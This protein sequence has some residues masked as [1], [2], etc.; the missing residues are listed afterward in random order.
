MGIVFLL[1]ILLILATNYLVSNRNIFFPSVIVSAVFFIS[2][3]LVVLNQSQWDYKVSFQTVCFISCALI[4][5][6]IGVYVGN[7]VG[8]LARYKK[9]TSYLDKNSFGIEISGFNM[10]CLSAISILIT[11]S[12][13]LHQY[14][15]AESLGNTRGLGGVIETIRSQVL[16]NPDVFQLGIVLNVGIVFVRALGFVCLFMVVSSILYG[17][18]GILKYL[19]PIACLVINIL[20]ATG[21]SAFITMVVSCLFFIYIVQKR[22]EV[23]RFNKKMIRYTAIG[24]I[25]FFVIFRLAG[26]LTGKSAILSLWDTVSIYAGSSVV[27]LDNFLLEMAEIIENNSLFGIKTFKGI[28]NL[29]N[30]LGGDFPQ[31]SNHAEFV[32]WGDGKYASNVYTAFYPYLQDFGV[33]CTLFMQVLIGFLFGVVWKRYN[34]KNAS[35]FL[36]ITYGV[37]FGTPLAFYSI[38][39][40]LFTSNLALNVFVEVFFYILFIRFV[41]HKKSINKS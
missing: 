27:C 5:F 30:K 10:I 21:R 38:A 20:F 28:Y 1:I 9:S 40:N 35:L 18:R 19:I 33:L 36:T 16:I 24:V 29:L 32:F 2:V 25:V 26:V 39:E 22:R 6:S 34:S 4:L 15:L 41:L 17:K 37:F 12:Y 8:R 31:G 7:R 23:L 3:L 14:K 13:G 11:I